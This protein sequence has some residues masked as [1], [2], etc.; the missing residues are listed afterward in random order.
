MY[1]NIIKREDK[2]CVWSWFCGVFDDFRYCTRVSYFDTC[3]KHYTLSYM[4]IH[5]AFCLLSA[6]LFSLKFLLLNLFSTVP[7]RTLFFLFSF[8]ILHVVVIVVV[9]EKILRALKRGT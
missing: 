1:F 3:C 4:K 8:F 6:Y 7:G 5:S 2:L 9:V